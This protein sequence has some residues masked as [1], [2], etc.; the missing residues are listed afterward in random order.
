VNPHERVDCATFDD[1]VDE[2]ALGHLDE[3][4]RS[5]LL[6][7]AAACAHCHASLESLGTIVDRL[8]LAAPEVEPPEG[9]ESRVLQ[10]IPDDP[11]ASSSKRSIGRWVVSITAVVVAFLAGGALVAQLDREP[12]PDVASIVT[13]DGA[14]IGSV[15]LVRDPVPHV[16]V[17][18]TSPRPDP[19]MR[20]CELQRPDG[21]WEQVGWWDERDIESGAWA[22]GI[23]PALL[24]ATAMRI[25]ADGRT[26]A[27]ATFD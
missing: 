2:L 13:A 19:G 27:A 6:A 15:Q 23:D 26:L 7:H 4:R 21:S 14:A 16:V 20:T 1:D 25:T 24:E 8:L 9:F 17:A 12:A 5:R 22:V 11:A 18:I 3:P 10:R